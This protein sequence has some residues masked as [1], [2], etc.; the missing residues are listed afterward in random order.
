MRLV[1][2]STAPVGGSTNNRL[3]AFIIIT[4]MS[5]RLFRK[6]SW[7]SYEILSLVEYFEKIGVYEIA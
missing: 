3:S 5:R 4:C 1:E 2:D 6:R 7:N